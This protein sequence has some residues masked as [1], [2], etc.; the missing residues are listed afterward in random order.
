MA[1]PVA[2]PTTSSTP[3]PEGLFVGGFARITVAELNVRTAPSMKAARLEEGQAD[4]PAIPVSWGTTSG[5]DRVFILAGPVDADG[6]RWWQVSPTEYELDGVSRPAPGAP[7]PEE[8]GWVAGGDGDS[9]WLIPANEC[10][11]TPFELA[12]ITL[13]KASWGVRLGC[14]QGQVLKLR[15]WLTTLPPEDGNSSAPPVAGRA[16]F[17]VQMGWNDKGNVNRL[18][19]RLHPAMSM[20]LPSPEQWIEVTGSFDDPTASQCEPF[21]VLACRATLTVTSVRPLGP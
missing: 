20:Q 1:T 15:G 8:I 19:F 13:L 4:A 11:E 21:E 7:N 14:F 16:I 17:P 9:A 3:R 12:D 5:S 6:Y 2:A 18:D 10:P